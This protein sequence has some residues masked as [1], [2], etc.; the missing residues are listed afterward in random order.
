VTSCFSFY[1]EQYEYIN[2]SIITYY[3]IISGLKHRDAHKQLASFFDFASENR[4]LPI[5]EHSVTVSSEIY[6]DLRKQGKPI[7]D[8]DILIAGIAI[9]NNM[10]LITHNQ[11]HF[12]RIR[13]LEIQDW[14]S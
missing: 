12:E 13:Q 14:S 9:S 1:L 2:F 4:I 11:S 3:E 5:T 8:M 7:D 10:V 6:A